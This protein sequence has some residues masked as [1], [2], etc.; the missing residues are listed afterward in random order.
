METKRKI[1]FVI[2]TERQHDNFHYAY[3]VCENKVIAR[4][5]GRTPESAIESL[6]G[7]SIAVSDMMTLG[8][9]VK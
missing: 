6:N 2:R 9:G 3:L 8:A 7:H 1:R 5:S 4:A